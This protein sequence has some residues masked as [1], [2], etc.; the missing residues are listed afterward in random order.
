MILA[1]R[2]DQP[3]VLDR[4]PWLPGFAI[5]VEISQSLRGTGIASVAFLTQVKQS[6]AELRHCLGRPHDGVLRVAIGT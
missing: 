1:T 2:F 6:H 4:Q 5:V 3:E